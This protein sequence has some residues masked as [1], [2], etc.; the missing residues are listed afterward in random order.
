MNMSWMAFGSDWSLVVVPRPHG[1]GDATSASSKDC[2]RW[3][4]GSGSMTSPRTSRSTS[5]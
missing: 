5:G 1:A 4:L 3:F 2:W